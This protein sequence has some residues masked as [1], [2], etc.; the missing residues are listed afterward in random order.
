MLVMRLGER[1]N[2]SLALLYDELHREKDTDFL[3]NKPRYVLTVHAHTLMNIKSQI[4]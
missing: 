1:W 2:K 3:H 4:R